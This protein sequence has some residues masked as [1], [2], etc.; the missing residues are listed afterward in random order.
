MKTDHRWLAELCLAACLGTTLPLA[1]AEPGPLTAWYDQAANR[2]EEALPLGNGRLGAMVYGGT[3][4]EHLQLNEDTLYS[5]WPGYR[6]TGVKIAPDFA[7]VTNL[8]ARSKFLEADRLVTE[9]WLGGA[10]ACYQPLGDL[11]LDFKHTGTPQNYRREL[12]L[13]LA[14]VRIGYVVDETRFTRECFISAPDQVMVIRLTAEG[15]AM[16][17]FQ[18]GLTTPHSNATTVATAKGDLLVKGQ[19]PGFVLRRDL[20]LVEKK[21]ETHKYPPLWDEKG[22]RKPGAKTVLYG[23]EIGGRGMRFQAA[24]RVMAPGAKIT[25]MEGALRVT[26]TR[27]VLLIYSAASSFNGYDRD[28]VKE[29]VD[30]SIAV[31]RALD[32]AA[33]KK[34]AGLRERHTTDYQALF[35]RTTLHLGSVAGRRQVATPQRLKEF[36]LAGDPELATLYFQFARYLM[37]SG[38]RPG[39]QPLNLQGLW[40][41]HIIPPWASAYTININ[42]EM[43]YWLAE[44]GNLPDCHEPLLRMVRELAVDGARVAKRMYGARGWVAHHNTTIWRCAEPVD[45][46]A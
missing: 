3:R 21:K 43:N 32:R 8:I 4:Q 42:A 16:L 22:E 44:A 10:Q 35:N 25:A 28:P 2:W 17:D 19:V 29:G 20:S 27:E 38:S 7:T 39:T 37:I 14:T 15:K 13:A 36:T 34:Y 41:P 31:Q 30:P 46:A 9:K 12:D 33:P 45:G 26:G 24:V 6:D 1:A 18:I 11:F 5:G 40:N 23:D